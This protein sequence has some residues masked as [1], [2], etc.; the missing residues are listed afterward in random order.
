[1]PFQDWGVASGKISKSNR[2]QLAELAAMCKA[3]PDVLVQQQ[4]T[5]R[6]VDKFAKCNN[7]LNGMKSAKDNEPQM[8][9]NI[10]VMPINFEENIFA[11]ATCS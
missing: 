4:Q 9:E 10:L 1:M 6:K 7:D 5:V 2:P 3:Q 11:G 8:R